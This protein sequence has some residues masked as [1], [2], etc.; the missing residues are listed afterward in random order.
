MDSTLD[1]YSDTDPFGSRF[2]DE[3]ANDGANLDHPRVS[4]IPL[5][6]ANTHSSY[7]DTLLAFSEG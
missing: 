1:G 2:V 7:T 4:H 3:T 5:P 6:R